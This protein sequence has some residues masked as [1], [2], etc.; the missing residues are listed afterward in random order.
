MADPTTSQILSNPTLITLFIIS[1]G[2]N[3]FFTIIGGIMSLIKN[4]QLVFLNKDLKQYD[5]IV[6]K[7]FK[8]K[9]Q[10]RSILERLFKD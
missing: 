5:F 1:L 8:H 10:N 4:V 7:R 2:L 6:Y 3:I 9:G